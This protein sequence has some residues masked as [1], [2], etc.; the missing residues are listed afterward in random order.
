MISVSIRC[1]HQT[2]AKSVIV[3]HHDL[4][5]ISFQAG[6]GLT[7]TDPDYTDPDRV[8]VICPS[9]RK[10]IPSIYATMHRHLVNYEPARLSVKRLRIIADFTDGVISSGECNAVSHGYVHGYKISLSTEALM[11]FN[12]ALTIL[13]KA[14]ADAEANQKTYIYGSI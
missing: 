13:R 7:Y 4:G 1:L 2:I 12:V 9:K 14:I 8:L 10:H 3:I 5:H 11:I 6:V